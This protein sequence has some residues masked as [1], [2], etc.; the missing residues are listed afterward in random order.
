MTDHY[1]EAT[2]ALNPPSPRPGDGGVRGRPGAPDPA[3]AQ[4]HATLAVAD[5]LYRIANALEKLIHLQPS[6]S[7]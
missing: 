3:A 6:K 1:E 4:V 2:K 5:E 7:Q